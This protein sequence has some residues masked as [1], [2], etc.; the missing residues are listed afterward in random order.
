MSKQKPKAQGL[1]I[2]FSGDL[3]SFFVVLMSCLFQFK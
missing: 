3:K 2:G 1:A